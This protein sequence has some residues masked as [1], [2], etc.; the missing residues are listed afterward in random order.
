MRFA[1]LSAT[2]RAIAPAGEIVHGEAGVRKAATRRPSPSL[3]RAR[4]GLRRGNRHTATGTSNRQAPMPPALHKGKAGPH[5]IIAQG[6]R[7]L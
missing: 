3:L 7:A 1:L 2:M 6:R 4:C 5:G